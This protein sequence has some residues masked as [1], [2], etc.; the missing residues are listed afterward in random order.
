MFQQFFQHQAAALFIWPMAAL[1]LFVLAFCAQLVVIL[2]TRK[3]THDANAQR[4][5]DDEAHDA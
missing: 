5:L 3:S 4:I 2:G 1:G